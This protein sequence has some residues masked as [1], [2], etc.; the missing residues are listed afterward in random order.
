MSFEELILT[1]GNEFEEG[2]DYLFQIFNEELDNAD[3]SEYNCDKYIDID[4][5]IFNGIYT[6][7]GSKRNGVKYIF[8]N[9]SYEIHIFYYDN[10]WFNLAYIYLE[11]RTTDIIVKPYKIFE[12]LT[13]EY[14]LK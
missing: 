4:C 5:N 8:K 3:Y 6:Y 11:S 1:N 13:N 10:N 9:S 14:I 12:I 7:N 2:K